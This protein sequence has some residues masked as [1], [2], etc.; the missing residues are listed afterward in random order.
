MLKRI[1]SFKKAEEGVVAVESVL[2]FPVFVLIAAV[3]VDVTSLVLSQTRMQSAAAD[4][5]RLVALGRISEAEAET[6]MS[7]RSTSVPYTTDIVIGT[8]VVQA[9]VEM[10]YSDLGGLGVFLQF[11]GSIGA[12]AFFR[13]E[14]DLS[15]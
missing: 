8:N 5:S 12:E 9:T 14:A 15:S 7:V 6:L 10:N 3:L 4:G 2:W 11:T 13:I 1:L